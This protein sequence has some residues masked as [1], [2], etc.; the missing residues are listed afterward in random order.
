MS[1]YDNTAEESSVYDA[2]TADE[3]TATE[4]I[5]FSDGSTIVGAD[6]FEPID[7]SDVSDAQIEETHVSVFRD[8]DA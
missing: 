5:H 2:E 1:T 7:V 4:T 8:P 3:Y 6:P